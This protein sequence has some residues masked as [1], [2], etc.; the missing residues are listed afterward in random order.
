MSVNNYDMPKYDPPSVPSKLNYKRMGEYKDIEACTKELKVLIRGITIAKRGTKDQNS[1]VENI[2]SHSL[3][4]T[5]STSSVSN[6]SSTKLRKISAERQNSLVKDAVKKGHLLSKLEEKQPDNPVLDDKQ[7]DEPT[8][9]KPL[10]KPPGYQSK[11]PQSTNLPSSPAT[12][13][14]T[15]ALVTSK[16]PPAPPPQSAKPSTVVELEGLQNIPKDKNAPSLNIQMRQGRQPPPLPSTPAPPAEDSQVD[17]KLSNIGADAKPQ[18]AARK[19]PPPLPSTPAPS[20]YDME[21][22]YDGIV[23]ISKSANK[24]SSEQFEKVMKE[25]LGLDTLPRN[26]PNIEVLASMINVLKSQPGTGLCIFKKN[27]VFQPKNN[28]QPGAVLIKEEQLNKIFIG[29]KNIASEKSV[30]TPAQRGISPRSGVVS[31]KTEQRLSGR[32]PIHHRKTADYHQVVSSLRSKQGKSE[33]ESKPGM[34]G[35][36]D[37]DIA[38]T[39][40]GHE[41]LTN[42]AKNI[43]KKYKITSVIIYKKLLGANTSDRALYLDFKSNTLSNENKGA[44]SKKIDIELL[45]EIVS[46]LLSDNATVENL[47][48]SINKEMA[49][50]NKIHTSATRLKDLEMVVNMLKMRQ[51]QIIEQNKAKDKNSQKE[52][53]TTIVYRDGKYML[54]LYKSVSKKESLSTRNQINRDIEDFLKFTIANELVPNTIRLSDTD[55]KITINILLDNLQKL[56]LYDEPINVIRLSAQEY[57]VSAANVAKVFMDADNKV[58]L[59]NLVEN[60]SQKTQKDGYK[61][62]WTSEEL[63]VSQLLGIKDNPSS[64]SNYA[65]QVYEIEKEY[66]NDTQTKIL[67]YLKDQNN[68]TK[69][70]YSELFPDKS[71]DVTDKDKLLKQITDEIVIA[72]QNKNTANSNEDKIKFIEKE[73][74]LNKL[75]SGINRFIENEKIINNPELM[76]VNKYNELPSRA[77][78]NLSDSTPEILGAI[79]KTFAKYCEYN[80]GPTFID[81]T[82]DGSINERLDAKNFTD[83][84]MN[85]L[86]ILKEKGINVDDFM[87]RRK[88]ISDLCERDNK[89]PTYEGRQNIL[90]K[91]KSFMQDFP[92]GVNKISEEE[93]KRHNIDLANIPMLY[94]KD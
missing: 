70:M 36:M 46:Q 48:T 24:P 42:E 10:P 1:K 14:A 28:P 83:W 55:D 40:S 47:K 38:A 50:Y 18:S 93:Y 71:I 13:Q 90:N 15:S 6:R 85:I 81:T 33:I 19:Q 44:N 8:P 23:D 74:K 80:Y 29:L 3:S 79:R 20:V 86:N 9:P 57:A 58:I 56:K 89:N 41:K 45:K 92:P 63:T 53:D 39:E 72:Q 84:N 66:S 11:A 65:S 82:A 25:A 73:S 49:I 88:E 77:I 35:E 12:S 64:V 52:M 54:D 69:K 67:D 26:I 51:N 16:T 2:R 37:K 4:E 75:Y 43:I 32:Q 22:V 17:Q 68:D 91:I 34:K 31:A 62:K 7:S 60:T 78:N 59:K 87:K 21:A 30:A 76:D 61:V 27:M 94:K 5:S